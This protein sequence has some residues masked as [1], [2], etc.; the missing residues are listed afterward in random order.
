MHDSDARRTALTRAALILSA[1]AVAVR[2]F[3]VRRT[4]GTVA[5]VEV[6]GTVLICRIS[7][8]KRV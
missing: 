8:S 3:F 5:L 6:P 1:S 2:V 4:G 7:Q